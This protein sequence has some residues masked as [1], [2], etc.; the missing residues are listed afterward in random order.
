MNKDKLKL[1]IV[2]LK[3]IDPNPDNVNLFTMDN[4]EHL[5][6][7]IKEE[8]FTTPIEVYEKSDG[9]YEITS[10]HRRYEAMK[11]LGETTIPCYISEQYESETLKDRKLLSSNI[12]TRKLSPYEMAKAIEF[13]EGILKRENFKG[14]VRSKTA[15][16]FGITESNVYRYKC[17]LNLIPKLQEYCKKQNFPYSSL[18]K[19]ATLSEDEQNELLEE[20][21]Y[22]KKLKS[23]A[24][25]SDDVEDKDELIFTRVAVEQIINQK[26]KKNQKEQEK[27]NT[28]DVIPVEKYEEY[29]NQDEESEKDEEYEDISSEDVEETV[30]TP[31]I[32]ETSNVDARVIEIADVSA[33][34][35]LVGL[36]ECISIL[37]AYKKN[38]RTIESKNDI[39]EKI[40][41]MK[42]IIEQIESLIQ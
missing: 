20:L 5:A 40:V 19:A 1:V 18:S 35:Y 17:I 3:N 15:E 23:N 14:N 24:L 29:Y 42:N 10:G 25:G 12:A 16:Y 31:I 37:Q 6:N 26:I 9:R 39:S 36:D 38:P 13:Y 22:L 27:K 28:E 4:I 32:V 21:M 33:G 41:V 8:G 34:S 2:E 11:L 30:Y 7:I